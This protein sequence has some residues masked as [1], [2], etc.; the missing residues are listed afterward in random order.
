[1][2]GPKIDSTT[3]KIKLHH[4]YKTPVVSPTLL[5]F[6]WTLSTMLT[7]TNVSKEVGTM[8]LAFL[9]ISTILLCLKESLLIHWEC[10]SSIDSKKLETCIFTVKLNQVPLLKI[11]LSP[12]YLQEVKLSSR[13]SSMPKMKDFLSPWLEKMS[14]LKW[15]VS[16]KAMPKEEI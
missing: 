3:L 12:S 9:N 1:M 16:I 10:Q 7:F 4:F 15:K 2:T 14:S 8:V 5:L 11:K 13:K 6:L